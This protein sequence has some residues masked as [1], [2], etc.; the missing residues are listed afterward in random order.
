MLKGIGFITNAHVISKYITAFNE[1][2]DIDPIIIHRSNFSDELYEA[3]LINYDDEEDIAILNVKSMNH[4]KYGLDYYTKSSKG[5]RIRVC[6]F[7]NYQLDNDMSE[8][9]GEISGER[10]SMVDNKPRFETNAMIRGGNSGGPAVNELNQVV[11]IASKGRGE[12]PNEII[13]IERV[14]MVAG[15]SEFPYK[16]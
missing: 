11:G 13:P 5:N 16:A 8:E 3:E 10:S 4:N 12:Y 6:G 2:K 15:S 1:T 14:L 7:P 9:F